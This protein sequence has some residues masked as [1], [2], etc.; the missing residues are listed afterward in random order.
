VPVPV[1]YWYLVAFGAFLLFVYGIGIYILGY[2]GWL[3]WQ[4]SQLRKT[5]KVEKFGL[6]LVMNSGESMIL[7]SKSKD[8]VLSIILNIFSILNSEVPKAVTFN[9]ETLRIEHQSINIGQ[10]YY[11]SFVSGQV[12]GDVVNN[13]CI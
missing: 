2:A 4:H 13:L 1:W 11:S 9:F 8:F 6:K 12:S 3:F 7:T 5:R 10:N